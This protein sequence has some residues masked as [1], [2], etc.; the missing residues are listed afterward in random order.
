MLAHFERNEGSPGFADLSLCRD[1]VLV[2]QSG[3]P[4]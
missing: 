4:I 1:Q 3:E 2:Y